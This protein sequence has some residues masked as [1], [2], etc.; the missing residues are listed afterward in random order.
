MT[1][2]DLEPIPLKNLPFSGITA[3]K[4]EPWKPGDTIPVN[5]VLIACL[6]NLETVALVGRD[7]NG[8]MYFASATDDVEAILQDLDKFGKF[9]RR[10]DDEC[11]N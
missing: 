8:E 7:I 2:D 1:Q 3:F 9:L 6:G 5:N 10:Y 4:Y 11:N